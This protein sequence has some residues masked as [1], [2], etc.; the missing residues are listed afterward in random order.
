MIAE[1][2]TI[3]LEELSEKTA[4]P[5]EQEALPMDLQSPVMPQEG[6]PIM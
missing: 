2:N 6:L 4:P 1:Y 3:S 5:Q